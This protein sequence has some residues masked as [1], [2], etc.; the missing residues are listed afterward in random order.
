M[1][2]RASRRGHNELRIG[3]E[4]HIKNNLQHE[5]NNKGRSGKD[6]SNQGTINYCAGDRG[7]GGGNNRGSTYTGGGAYDGQ[8]VKVDG[9]LN[10]THYNGMPGVIFQA[11]PGKATCVVILSSGEK[12]LCR[13]SNLQPLGPE[14][15]PSRLSSSQFTATTLK[16]RDADIH[17]AYS[18]VESASDPAG[19]M[20]VISGSSQ[21]L[22]LTTSEPSKRSG[23]GKRHHE[24]CMPRKQQAPL[25]MRFLQ[26][27]VPD[28]YPAS[29]LNIHHV[30][31][32]VLT[33]GLGS[34]SMKTSAKKVR[35]WLANTYGDGKFVVWNLCKVG[36]EPQLLDNKVVHLPSPAFPSLPA[37]RMLGL[38]KS[39]HSWLSLDPLHVAVLQCRTGRGRSAA[40]A[41]C[42]LHFADPGRFQMVEDALHHVAR[43]RDLTLR[44][45]TNPTQIRF[46]RYFAKHLIITRE[47]LAISSNSAQSSTTTTSIAN[48][49]PA[50]V[51]ATTAVATNAL[52]F[53]NACVPT[54]LTKTAK[55]TT[56]KGGHSNATAHSPPPPPPPPPPSAPPS[57]HTDACEKAS[58]VGYE[59]GVVAGEPDE[60]RGKPEDKHRGKSEDKHI[61]TDEVRESKSGPGKDNNKDETDHSDRKGTDI[62]RTKSSSA[63]GVSE[64]DD[65]VA[66]NGGVEKGAK[67]K[68]GVD[69]KLR[70][71]FENRNEE[72]HPDTSAPHR[73]VLGSNPEYCLER[74]IINE[75]PDVENGSVRPYIQVL[76]EHKLVFDGRAA[77][78]RSPIIAA[79][80]SGKVDIGI[81][82]EDAIP[83]QNN[84]LLT[85][86]PTPLS[87]C[88]T[89]IYCPWQCQ[90]LFC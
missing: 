81:A 39:V 55:A 75:A 44:K 3:D 11:N 22:P 43:S 20:P 65:K 54:T 38:C 33:L 82:G 36:Y 15:M 35:D 79:G 27:L 74:V 12:L 77:A 24:P 80:S 78:L 58:K 16:D 45:L 71:T 63:G 26:R 89:Y 64:A 37:H 28:S 6:D 23:E 10:D 47:M 59:A 84:F 4:K 60:H 66:T 50:T 68:G 2:S 70:A 7:S 87:I 48:V 17:D 31:K 57:Q 85:F 56:T 40:A 9:L 49:V 13:K 18:T 29:S 76:S 30:S 86:V 42:Y 73:T 62:D 34:I 5:N 90:V 1:A 69:K 67:I 41:A 52:T 72:V 88:V 19:A 14:M 61:E 25:I 51:I 46:C 21:L 32:N 8:M 53:N 83:C